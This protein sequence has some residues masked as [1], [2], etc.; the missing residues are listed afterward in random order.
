MWEGKT[1]V[2]RSDSSQGGV[3]VVRNLFQ[4]MERY[5][6]HGGDVSFYFYFFFKSLLASHNNMFFQPRV[7]IC[8]NLNIYISTDV[9][10]HLNIRQ[11]NYIYYGIW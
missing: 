11:F 4:L 9:I 10:G 3:K 1:V 8:D 2:R 6:G 5:D 7:W